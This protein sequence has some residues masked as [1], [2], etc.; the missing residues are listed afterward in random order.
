MSAWIYFVIGVIVFVA[1]LLFP[2]RRPSL[3]LNMEIGLALALLSVTVALDVL[4]LLQV[5]AAV[6]LVMLLLQKGFL[7]DSA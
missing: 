6:V 4:P 7:R 1:Y 2:G 3:Q 5:A